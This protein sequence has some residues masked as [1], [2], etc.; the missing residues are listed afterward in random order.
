MLPVEVGTTVT[1]TRSSPAC[2]PKAP[3]VSPYSKLICATS[4]E[5]TPPATAT[6]AHSSDQVLRSPRLYPT[7]VG[8]EMAPDVEWMR[9]IFSSGSAKSP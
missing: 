9:M 4:C 1:P 8:L 7:T 2:M 3:V 6:R 5:C